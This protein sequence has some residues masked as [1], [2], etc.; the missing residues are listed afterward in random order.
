MGGQVEL[1]ASGLNVSSV[2][3]IAGVVGGDRKYIAHAVGHK[4]MALSLMS[5]ARSFIYSKPKRTKNALQ[6]S[7]FDRSRQ[8][9]DAPASA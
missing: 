7:P 8:V 3:V 9:H 4:R 2:D 5:S 1:A 6:V